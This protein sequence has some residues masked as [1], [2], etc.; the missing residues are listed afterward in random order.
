MKISQTGWRLIALI[1]AA[2]FFWLA[3]RVDVYHATSPYGLASAVFGSSAPSVPHP[4]WLALHIWVRKFY[5]I[6]AFAL[7]GLMADKALGA[8]RRPKLRGLCLVA[9]Y[10]A[11]IE[12]AQHQ[13]D[14]HEPLFER[15][16][17]VACGAAG[18]YI[19]LFALELIERRPQRNSR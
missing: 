15:V 3:T 16:L 2:G 12:L 6:V 9:L 13:F 7:V 11:A 17:D 10:S 8:A 18:G 4:W 1:A 5:G 19:G 14:P